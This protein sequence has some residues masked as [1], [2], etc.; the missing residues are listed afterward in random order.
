VLEGAEFDDDV[1]PS[2][3]P[4]DPP[5]AHVATACRHPCDT[6]LHAPTAGPSAEGQSSHPAEGVTRG[7]QPVAHASRPPTGARRQQGLPP[8]AASGPV[9]RQK[10]P[11][12]ED[13]T[14]PPSTHVCRSPL[15]G[16]L[17]AAHSHPVDA[18]PA[19]PTGS[20]SV[21]RHGRAANGQ[22][23]PGFNPILCRGV[24]KADPD[25]AV[26]NWPSPQ[27]AQ[28]TASRLCGGTAPSGGDRGTAPAAGEGRAAPSVVCRL[29]GRPGRGPKGQSLPDPTPPVKDASSAPAGGV[30]CR[31]GSRYGR[32][33]NGKFLK[34]FGPWSRIVCKPDGHGPLAPAGVASRSPPEGPDP[35]QRADVRPADRVGPPDMKVVASWVSCPVGGA[36]MTLPPPPSH[37]SH[38]AGDRSAGAKSPAKLAPS[39]R[40]G[41][42][43]GGAMCSSATAVFPDAAAAVMPRAVGRQTP[44]AQASRDV[45]STLHR[46]A[47]LD[48]SARPPNGVTL[49][50][51]VRL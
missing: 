17:S 20:R 26:A 21:G 19:S 9:T 37:A 30:I 42:T 25:T 28:T 43:H 40:G 11:R 48:L 27:K 5:A 34:G 24:F 36:G 51:G 6:T 29:G 16:F 15:P 8:R 7:S 23:L 3:P 46:Q 13:A 41:G 12:E 38:R 49:S 2:N 45:W 32:G 14:A 39:P 31:S 44:I 33:P 1:T 47:A 10:R 22:L 18:P 4:C 50:G 35:L